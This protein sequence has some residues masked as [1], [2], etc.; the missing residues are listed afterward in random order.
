MKIAVFAIAA[1]ALTMVGC[2]S[3]PPTL[4]GADTY[5]ASKTN[6]AGAFGDPSAVAGKLMADGNVFCAAQGREFQLVT[7]TINPARPAASLGGA[8]ITFKCTKNADPV[9]MRPD[10]GVT[11]IENR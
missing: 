2:A 11:T 1:G 3:T 7:Q 10:N 4:I 8:S 9:T 5:Y 6:S